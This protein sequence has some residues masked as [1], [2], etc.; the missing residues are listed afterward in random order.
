MAFLFLFMRDFGLIMCSFFIDFRKTKIKAI[1][2]GDRFS[3]VRVCTKAGVR[4][5]PDYSQVGTEL[6]AKSGSRFNLHLFPIC[7]NSHSFFSV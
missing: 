4:T 2:T 1:S 3:T 7:I 5:M 6:R